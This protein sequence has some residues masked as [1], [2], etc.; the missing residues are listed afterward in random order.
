MYPADRISSEHPRPGR[1]LNRGKQGR[2]LLDPSSEFI[3][4]ILHMQNPTD[5]LQVDALVL[6]KPLDEPKPGNVAR[7]IP[8]AAFW[9]TPRRYQAH[10]V[11]GSQRL[12]VHPSQMS[13]NRD[14][15]YGRVM[16]D[17]LRQLWG[18]HLSPHPA[19]KSFALGFTEPTASA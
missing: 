18:R 4:V 5:A 3:D 7:R 19:A 1:F 8:P 16:I 14:H 17:S 9:R 13:C 15:E 12:R 10:A 6:G 2:Q 11:V